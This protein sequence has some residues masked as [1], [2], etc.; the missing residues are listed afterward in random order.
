MKNHQF[1]SLFAPAAA[2]LIAFAPTAQAS[3]LAT[4]TAIV[5]VS[6]TGGGKR[7]FLSTPF[8]RAVEKTGTVAAVASA[9]SV[10]LTNSTGATY[11]NAAYPHIVTGKQIGRAHV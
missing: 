2:A 7:D 10:T 6:F 1:S 11:S 5:Q 9:T 8:V 4:P 3:S